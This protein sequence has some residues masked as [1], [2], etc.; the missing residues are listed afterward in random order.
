MEALAKALGASVPL[1]AGY[2]FLRMSPYRRY[3]AEHLRTDRFALHV[4]EF[5]VVCYAVGVLTA[6]FILAQILL[7]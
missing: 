7:S 3:R 1:L 6:S 4:F 5:S 2:L